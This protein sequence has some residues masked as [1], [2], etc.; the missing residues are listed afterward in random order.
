LCSQIKGVG[1]SA[2]SINVSLTVSFQFAN[3]WFY[4]ENNH[5]SRITGLVVSLKVNIIIYV[6]SV[7]AF[8]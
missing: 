6:D 4:D 2:L 1:V 7:A 5:I 8:L 3:I